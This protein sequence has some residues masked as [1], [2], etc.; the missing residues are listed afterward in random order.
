MYAT[1]I[2]A[3]ALALPASLTPEPGIRDH[4]ERSY[5]CR[6]EVAVLADADYWSGTQKR[7]VVVASADV[8]DTLNLLGG[9][10]L[11]CIYGDDYHGMIV[12][13]GEG[14]DTIITYSGSHEMY[15]DGGNDI[16]YL[17][18]YSDWVD[19]G[20][21]NDHIWG[22]GSGGVYGYGGIGTDMLQGSAYGDTL[23]GGDDGDL[24]IGAGGNDT[25]RGD[26]G[27]DTLQGGA[28][29]D[30]LHGGA[31]DDHCEDSAATTYTSCE[32]IP[33]APP[34]PEAG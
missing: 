3:A 26:D 1:W 29:V 8:V 11:A 21:G 4:G 24:I 9:D 30:N 18:G 12:N 14:H 25:L 6:G 19:G 7:D 23:E 20:S 16:L 22:L 13:A 2:A 31:D 33:V 28:G 34:L 32:T 5:E 15:G 27:N 17:N 10:D